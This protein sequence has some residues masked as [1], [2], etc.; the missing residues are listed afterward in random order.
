VE[1]GNLIQIS[2][3]GPLWGILLGCDHSLGHSGGNEVAG[4]DR[5][6]CRMRE[7]S[8][9]TNEALTGEGPVQWPSI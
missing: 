2:Q 8:S 4:N 5:R 3:A 6:D 9:K 1:P 7:R